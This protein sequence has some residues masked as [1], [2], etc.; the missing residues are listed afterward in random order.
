MEER[1]R[2]VTREGLGYSTI[3]DVYVDNVHVGY[4][5]NDPI[6]QTFFGAEVWRPDRAS[7]IRLE[8]RWTRLGSGACFLS[9][10][11]DAAKRWIA[12]N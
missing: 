2:L 3:T 8:P 5:L 4:H 10:V 11:I 9:D 7:P 1:L 6:L 12:A